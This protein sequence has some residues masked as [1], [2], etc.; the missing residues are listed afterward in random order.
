LHIDLTVSDGAA[1]RLEAQAQKEQA[2]PPHWRSLAFGKTATLKHS[3][4]LDH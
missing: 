3:P 4:R 1:P 2:S